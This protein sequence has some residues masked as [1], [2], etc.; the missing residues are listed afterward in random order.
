MHLAKLCLPALLLALPALAQP[1]PPAAPPAAQPAADPAMLRAQA[2]FEAL[3]EAERK[4]IQNDL[5]FATVFSGAAAGSFGPLTFRAIQAFEREGRHTVD[6]VLDATERRA[7]AEAA[8]RARAATRF[9]VRAD[10]A[11]RAVIGVP[12]ALLT[13]AESN[14]AGG[15]RWQ[16][17][18]GKATLNT[19]LVKPEEGTLEQ[20]YERALV[21]SNPDRKVTYRLLR[22]DFYVVAGE[23]PQ[24][25]F[26]QRVGK[27]ADGALRGF[28]IGYDKASAAVWDKLTVAIAN[29]FD[30]T[31]G[32]PPAAGRPVV[33]A[34][35]TA[36]AAATAAAGQATA[37]T[38]APE[39]SLTGLAVAPGRVLTAAGALRTCAGPRVG[40]TAART[41]AADEA[42]GLALLAVEGLQAP[43]IGLSTGAA[44]ADPVALAHGAR[45]NGGRGLMAVPVE[46]L[47]PATGRFRAAIQPGAAGAPVFGRA[48]GF[49]GLVTSDP[50]A[51]FQVAGVVLAAAHRMAPAGAVSAFLAAQG[52]TPGGIR[53]GGLSGQMASVVEIACGR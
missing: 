28:S 36:V 43:A 32:A 39:R 25:K 30:P 31:P 42:S 46:G 33:A 9:S 23:T 53:P 12:E 20:L 34:A 5:T 49:A 3:P 37:P 21:S 44:P 14:P 22:P 26:Y 48:G 18:D 41:L 1:R 4:A 19:R 10:A 24:G 7:L 51:R 16:T 47:D 15:T 45:P 35:G 40:A 52:V 11:S 27:G 29:S 6:G 50:S 8:G 17:A 13:R 2:A 38:R